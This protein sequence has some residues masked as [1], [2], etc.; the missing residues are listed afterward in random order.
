MGVISGCDRAKP[1]LC[2][3]M[4]NYRLPFRPIIAERAEEITHTL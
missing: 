3:F 2:E 1:R 4:L